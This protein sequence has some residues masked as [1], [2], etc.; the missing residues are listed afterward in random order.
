MCDNVVECI[1]E[2]GGT[3]VMTNC[4]GKTYKSKINGNLFYV[5][6]LRMDCGQELYKVVDT[7]VGKNNYISKDWFEHGIMQNLE[8]VTK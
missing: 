7:G 8:E 4:V 3:K 5:K 6:E 2:R 1:T